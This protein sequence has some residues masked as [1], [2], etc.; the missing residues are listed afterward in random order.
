MRIGLG[1]ALGLLLCPTPGL[2][3]AHAQTFGPSLTPTAPPKLQPGLMPLYQPNRP[4][5]SAGPVKPGQDIAFGAYQRG[6]YVTAFQEA[7]QRIEKNKADAAAMTLVAEIYRD[8]SGIKKNP[9]EAARWYKLAADRGDPQAQFQLAAATLRGEGVPENKAVA[10]SL[11]EKAAAQGHP[12]ALYNLGIMAIDADIQDFRAAADFFRRAAERGNMDGAYSLA[13]LYREGRGVPQDIKEAARW[14]RRAAD[15]HIA[16]AEVEL[17]IMTFNGEGVEKD[18][19]AAAKLFLRAAVR[20]NPVAMNRLAR[21]YASGRGVVKNPVEAMKWHLLARAV[22][23]QDE[24]LDGVLNGLSAK[25]RAE[26]E[27]AVKKFVGP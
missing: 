19:A 14:L 2:S 6:Y 8:G 3:P 11:L 10:K 22:G 1:L 17:A 24:F 27:A 4:P 13:V 9:S 16:A 20:N 15:E 21:I 12:G 7:M 26:V 23:L 25:E 5:P 18:E